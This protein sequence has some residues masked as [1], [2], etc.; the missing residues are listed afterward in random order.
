[1]TRALG[2]AAAA[3]L[4]AGLLGAAGSALFY[5]WHPAL[6]IELDRDLPARSVSGVYSPERD[7]ATGLTFAWSGA[8]AIVRLPGLD[9]GRPWIVELRLRGGR[10]QNENP[11]VAVLA[12]GAVVATAATQTEWSDVRA[13]IPARPERRGLMLA[14]HSSA[15]FVPGGSD[16]RA[17]GVMI[18]R[19][20]LTPDGIVLVP[21]GALA[22][23]A[24]ASAAMGAA[25]ALLGISAGSA[26]GGA[27]L[28]SAGAAAI[29]ARGFGPFT[30]YPDTALAL[31]IWIAIGLAAIAIAWQYLLG[32][33]L[34]N[35][36]RFA[37]AFAA[38]AL[39]L[40]LLVLLHP[41]MP[42]GDA[43][44][45]AHRF[46]GVLAGKLFF[47][48]IAPGGYAFPYPPGLYVFAAAFSGLVRRGAADVVL[49]RVVTCA[50][51]AAVSVLL[52][53]VVAGAW[54]NRLAGA[55]AV[56]IYHL[57]PIDFAVLTTG[58][59]TNA[60]A[61]SLAVA[62]LVL[63][64]SDA[65]S[66]ERRRWVVLL[67]AAL[68][69]AYLSHTSTV[70]IVFV[71]TMASATL[72]ALRGGRALRS[73]AA[74]VAMASL[75]AAILAVALYYARFLDTYRTELA[76]IG[77]ETVANAA[78]AGGR[79]VGDRLAGVPYSLRINFGWPALLLAAF[80]GVLAFRSRTAD[81][82]SLTTAGWLVSCAL[83]LALGIL[84]PIDMRYYLAAL[85]A[86]AIL[87]GYGGASAWSDAPGSQRTWRR[88]AAAALLA[89][90]ILA[91]FRNWWSALG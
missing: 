15:T 32:R 70:A 53:W 44:F 3:A 30:S 22:A 23:T 76:R 9:R 74:A 37:A 83:F 52:Y 21:R 54:R 72:F 1:M 55:M 39:F 60:F 67:G 90:T 36:A 31:G 10:P 13:T 66:L 58:N 63:T 86:L 57:L 38:A 24:L 69:A 47:T 16:A 27:V 59:L 12:D 40:K 87:G 85:P 56:A 82:L 42:I 49:L 28:L 14:L 33:T 11:S 43:M 6:R 5:A 29:V 77:H 88:A 79:T 19:L 65:V 34:R 80:G 35:T 73:G 41:D 48:S 7:A 89:G 20:S 26:I 46:Q 18:D 45:H 4:I 75:G 81:R 71:A 62:A 25:L 51:D 68:L 84:T 78:D 61:Q 64:A 8:D 50:A 2:R 91:G 17:L